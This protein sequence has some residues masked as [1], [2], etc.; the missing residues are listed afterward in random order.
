MNT[1]EGQQEWCK[2]P[3]KLQKMAVVWPC[4][5][6]ERGAR[7]GKNARCGHAREIIRR[8]RPNLSGNTHARET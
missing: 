4:D 6:N 5:E 1:L 3:R 2:R 7:R 8:G